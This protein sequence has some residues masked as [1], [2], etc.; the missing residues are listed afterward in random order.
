M[1]S[2]KQL[3]IINYILLDNNKIFETHGDL[4]NNKFKNN[5]IQNIQH[6]VYE[7]FKDYVDIIYLKHELE[8]RSKYFQP[9]QIVSN[10]KN[11]EIGC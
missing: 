3:N 1:I 9:F 6:L 2:C 4:Y 8:K 7:Q 5:A 10:V 11:D